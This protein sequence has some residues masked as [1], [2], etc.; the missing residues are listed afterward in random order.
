MIPLT[1]LVN[2]TV[3]DPKSKDDGLRVLVMRLWPRGIKKNK[4][5]VWYKDL[6]TQKELIKAWK[7][8]K[9]TR[10]EFRKKYLAN[11]RV[12]EKKRLLEELAERSRTQNVTLLC[13]CRDPNSCHRTFLKDE[14]EKLIDK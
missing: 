13:G 10:R 5:D 9:V 3:Y 14:I 4:V 7:A 8:G 2:K 6:G 12:A 11:L 1:I